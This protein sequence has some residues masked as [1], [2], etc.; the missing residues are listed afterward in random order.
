VRHKSAARR[1]GLGQ[2]LLLRRGQLPAQIFDGTAQFNKDMM[3][4]K[5]VAL[6]DRQS[7]EGLG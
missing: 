6:P 5:V 7:I 1:I 2:L 3:S 4:H